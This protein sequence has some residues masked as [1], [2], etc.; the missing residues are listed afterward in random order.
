MTRSETYRVD[1]ESQ[2]FRIYPPLLRAAYPLPVM[3]VRLTSYACLAQNGTMT[4]EVTN[5][6]NPP[7]IP[8]RL[9]TWCNV[10]MMKRLV[11]GGQFI[12]YTCPKCI[13]Q[14]T[15]NRGVQ[16]D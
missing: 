6:P 10:P 4:E 2:R 7:D 5:Q 1:R 13:F 12:H 16:Q 9:C 14:H 3:R 8:D 15:T 11:G